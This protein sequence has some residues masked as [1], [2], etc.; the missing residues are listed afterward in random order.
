M[1]YL[2]QAFPQSFPA[3]H[4]KAVTENEIYKIQKGLKWKRSLG[5]DKVPSWIVKLSMPFISSPLIYIC[6]TMLSTGVFP[7]RLKF[8]QI[9]PMFKAS[10]K[11]DMPAYRPISVLTSL[12]KLFEKVIYN[13]LLQHTKE[14]SIITMD[15]Y[16]FKSSS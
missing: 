11:T 5:Y 14:N 13:R 1:Q 16:G 9:S 15:Q 7:T 12:S 4:L 3:I 6:N 10:D 8:S 2:D